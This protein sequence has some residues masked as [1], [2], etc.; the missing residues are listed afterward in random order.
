MEL[1][2]QVVVEE[3]GLGF[4][5]MAAMGRQ[6][7]RARAVEPAELRALAVLHP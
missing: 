2:A 4:R 3:A 1:V 5:D 7:P 6:L